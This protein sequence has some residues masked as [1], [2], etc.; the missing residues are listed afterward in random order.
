MRSQLWW[1]CRG[2]M[3]DGTTRI[4]E[5]ALGPERSASSEQAADGCAG[6]AGSG[7]TRI[8]AGDGQPGAAAVS[9][10]TLYRGGTY[11]P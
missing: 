11:V 10:Y 6:P 7:E 3:H 2:V 4:G 1:T 9:V 8:G 5:R